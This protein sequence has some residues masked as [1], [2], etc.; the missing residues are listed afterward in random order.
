MPCGI[1]LQL[2]TN[3]PR[4]VV[5]ARLAAAIAPLPSMR[6]KPI[7]VVD[8]LSSFKGKSFI[9]SL[10][11]NQFKL[12]LLNTKMGGIRWRGNAVII[13][14]TIEDN[15]VRVVL[16]LPI[17]TLLFSLFWTAA[18]SFGFVLSFYGSSNTLTVHLLL[19]AMLVLP[20]AIILWTFHYEARLA[21]RALRNVFGVD[22]G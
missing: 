22:A 8:W 20:L 11:G 12:G 14:G 1:H 4:Q 5:E 16:R 21:E 17:F 7:R 2:K 3:E 13:V 19:A 9:G 10:N 18:L 15:M 6:I